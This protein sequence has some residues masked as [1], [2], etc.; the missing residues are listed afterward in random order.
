MASA[1]QRLDAAPWT[2]VALQAVVGL[3]AVVALWAASAVQVLAGRSDLRRGHRLQALVLGPSL[4]IAALAAEGFS[5]WL[6]AVDPSDLVWT[7]ET[8]AAPRG[9][10]VMLSGP[11]RGRPPD[12]EP[13][14]LIDTLGRAHVAS[15]RRGSFWLTFSADGKRAAWP[16]YASDDDHQPEIV[17]AELD[18]S[19][20]RLR[21]LRL[22]TVEQLLRGLALSADGSRLAILEGDRL[23]VHDT[24]TGQLLAVDRV[25]D[26][27]GVKESCQIGFRTSDRVRVYAKGERLEIGELDVNARKLEWIATVDRNARSLV[28]T[29]GHDRLLHGGLGGAALIDG[30]TG[31]VLA[32]FE[33]GSARLL[34]DGRVAVIGKEDGVRRLRVMSRDG[35]EERSVD[36]DRRLEL[37]HEI[38]PGVLLAGSQGHDP[39]ADGPHWW[40]GWHLAL[41]DVD[42]AAVHELGPGFPVLSGFLGRDRGPCPEPGSA[43]SRLVHL[44]EGGVGLY[45]VATGEV[46]PLLGERER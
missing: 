5:R 43:G 25:A 31:G 30:F 21:D 8:V 15:G 16:R 4:V 29:S 20:P 33:G 7:R 27:L 12:F 9:D 32:S 6:V 11:T 17:L 46:A 10:W 34:A 42:R 26:R 36:L 40:S 24:R 1:V 23:I 37:G 3:L 38:M 19:P 41:V 45:D 2:R 39:E 28:W 14:F 18:A 13:A 22:V 44:L 35:V